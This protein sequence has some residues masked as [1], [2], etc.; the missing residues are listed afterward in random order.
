MYRETASTVFVIVDRGAGRNR[1]FDRYASQALVIA[2]GGE[3]IDAHGAAGGDVTGQVL[4]DDQ[5]EAAGANDATERRRLGA[6]DVK[7]IPIAYL[8][9]YVGV[10]LNARESVYLRL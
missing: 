1:R 6:L 2:E 10:L 3:G 8:L 4:L 7:E 5:G 9:W